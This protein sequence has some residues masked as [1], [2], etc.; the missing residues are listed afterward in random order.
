MSWHRPVIINRFATDDGGQA[1]ICQT[2]IAFDQ[3]PMPRHPEGGL[4][5]LI[6]QALSLIANRFLVQPA[7]RGE[8]RPVTDRGVGPSRV[9][10]TRR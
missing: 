3:N 9:G 2:L 1:S 8:E 4:I 10:S 7:H 6:H 5:K